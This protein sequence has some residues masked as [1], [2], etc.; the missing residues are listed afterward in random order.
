MWTFPGFTAGP[1]A[2][3]SRVFTAASVGLAQQSLT[4]LGGNGLGWVI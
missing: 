3:R 4:L 1:V 2:A